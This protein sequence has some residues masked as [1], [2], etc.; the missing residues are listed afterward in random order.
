MSNSFIFF[1]L[2]TDACDNISVLRTVLFIKELLKIVFILVPIGLIVMLSV[3][4]AKNVISGK[5][6]EMR[7]NF[8]IAMKRLIYIVILFLVPTIVSFAINSLGN[9][10]SGYSKCLAVT[11][12]SIDRQIAINKG[13]CTGDDYEWDDVTSECVL[14]SI[15]PEINITTSDGKA[16]KIN[17]NNKSGNKSLK[18]F[19]QCDSKWRNVGYCSRTTIC[20]SGC[21]ATS[22]AIIAASFGSTSSASSTNPKVMRDYLC[23]NKIHSSGATAHAVMTNTK[24]LKHFG[25]T[26]KLTN[27]QNTT[28][29]YNKNVADKLK[30]YVDD[31]KGVI[32]LIPG[33]YVV[34]GQNSQCQSDEV[35]L[36][37]VASKQY[38]GCKTMKELWNSTYNWRNRCKNSS[39]CGWKKVWVYNSA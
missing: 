31:G 4:L 21:G 14:K 35:Y 19:S 39:N 15:P 28:S 5:D 16:I 34:V 23:N 1:L 25:L 17:S 6:D 32:I 10:E 30:K 36:Y 24:L 33:H 37:N 38:C 8:S 18:Y 26:G 9:F 7:K 11:N 20:N 27:V 22:L 12:D 29:K 2:V 13:K 3:D